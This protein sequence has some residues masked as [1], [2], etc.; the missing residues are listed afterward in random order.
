MHSQPISSPTREAEAAT[1]ALILDL[2]VSGG[3]ALWTID[4]LAREV[5]HAL[6]TKDAVARLSAAGLLHRC[7]EFV[8]AS[9]AGARTRELLASEV[10]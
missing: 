2:L 10:A 5:G 4:E 1:D 6:D 7:G 8:L 3:S 9:R